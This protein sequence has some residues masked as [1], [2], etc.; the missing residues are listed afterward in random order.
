MERKKNLIPFYTIVDDINSQEF[1]KYDVMPYLVRSYDDK[2]KDERPK[3]FDEFKKF[4]ENA[5]RY[6]Y[7]ARCEYE[8]ILKPWVSR[9]KERKIDVHWQLMNNLD[10]VTSL[11]MLNLGF[12]EENGL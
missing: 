9:T 1:V 2:K 4:I 8:V 3:T 5:S 10:V 11:L 7:W 6:M 12:K